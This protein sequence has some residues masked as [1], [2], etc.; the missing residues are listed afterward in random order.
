MA[1]SSYSTDL[2]TA[3]ENETNAMVEPTA[4]GWT[5]LSTITTAE[6]DY[7]IQHSA[8]TS[9]TIKTGVGGL[10]TNGVTATIPTDGA[11]FIWMYFTSPNCLD[12]KTNGGIRFMIGSGTAAFYGYKMGGSDTYTYGG[13][14]CLVCGDPSAISTASYTLG[15]PTSTRSFYGWAY[16]APTSVPGKGN[17]Y[18][19]DAIRYGR[20]TIQCTGGDLAN[21]YATFVLAAAKNDANDATN[22]WNRWG[23]FSYQNGGYVHQGQFLM[24]TASTAVDFRD[25]N[26]NITILPTEWVTSNFNLYE[27]R[28]ASSRVDWTA[29]SITS[30]PG[31]STYNYSSRGN[32]LVTNNAIVNITNCTF[33]DM[34]TFVFYGGTNANTITN[35]IF[36]RCK[37]VTQ[38]GAT[39][40]G[41][42]FDQS[43]DT[44][45]LVIDTPTAVTNCSFVSSGTGYAIE[46]F[47]TANASYT[48]TGLTF[49][50][51]GSTGT[52]NAAIHVLA[53]TG[54]TTINCSGSPTYKSDGAT[55]NIVSGTV[56]CTV[57]VKDLATTNA[58]QYARV[59][60]WVANGN[61]KPYQ[62]SISITSSGTTATVTHSSH[63]LST[64]DKVIISGANEDAYNGV[65]SITYSSSTQYTYTMQASTTSPAT[66]TITATFAVINGETGSDGTLVDSRTW[67]SNQA[68]TGWV[69]KSTTTYSA[70]LYKEQAISG[71]ISSS[72]GYSTTVQLI[73]DD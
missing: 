68:I 36:R 51:Y 70:A 67:G 58:V 22:G 12:T 41:C 33:T 46:G 17:P 72:S 53:T 8:C 7:F 39:F 61:N 6:T 9:A 56:D 71:T 64:G 59:L 40:T 30:L 11:I 3:T 43:A 1:A 63:G 38:A 15:S 69:R 54:T 37:V 65:F 48:L 5:A 52:T 16:N 50:G 4:T 44:K 47:G 23:L 24:G 31:S 73:R 21:G 66:G 10:M 19:V 18:G 32:F 35:T 29:I 20:G 42:T 27:I 26:R 62:A 34:G 55:V 28:N 13:W 45:A 57:V 49:S 2:S 60:V 14:L 25:S